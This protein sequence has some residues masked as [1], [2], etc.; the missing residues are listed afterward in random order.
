MYRDSGIQSEKMVHE[1]LKAR[2]VKCLFLEFRGQ[3]FTIVKLYRGRV[4]TLTKL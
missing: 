1:F 3:G 2:L 4:Q